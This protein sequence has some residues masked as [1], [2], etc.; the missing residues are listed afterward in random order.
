MKLYG[1]HRNFE[2]GFTLVEL[3][4]VVIILAILA[5]IVVPQFATSTDDANESSL[6]TTLVNMRGAVD[7][8][9]QQHGEYP[10]GNTAVPG[11][12]CP[13]GGTAGTGAGDDAQTFLDQMTLYT[14]LNGEACSTTDAVY[15]YG[16]YL[17]TRTIPA[18]PIT[19][20]DTL[21]VVNTGDLIMAGATS[22]PGG[23]RFDVVTGRFIADDSDN[24]D[25]DGVTYD[26]H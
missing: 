11:G 24:T 2:T 13:S 7:L 25:I 4:I 17:R 12:T 19:A 15:K 5:A 9:Y 21:V 6:D 1:I 8:Y 23:W 22:P 10:G 3:L 16:P 14:D 20:D 18:N 26:Q